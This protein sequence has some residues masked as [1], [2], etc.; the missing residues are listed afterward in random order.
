MRA[1]QT[2]DISTVS[3]FFRRPPTVSDNF[4]LQFPYV[5]FCEHFKQAFMNT[6]KFD[7]A[8]LQQEIEKAREKVFSDFFTLK[9]FLCKN[10]GQNV[11]D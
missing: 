6:W 4:Q 11:K 9:V 3:G 10:K 1:A 7:L 5:N 2:P 8:T